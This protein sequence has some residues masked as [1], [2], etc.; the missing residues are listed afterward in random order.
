MSHGPLTFR[1]SGLGS[2]AATER[3]R[4]RDLILPWQALA[5]VQLVPDSPPPRLRV[6]EASC[7]RVY[8]PRN[9]TGS[10]RAGE[11]EGV[12]ERGEMRQKKGDKDDGQDGTSRDE[13]NPPR[14][15]TLPR[16]A[17]SPWEQT[18]RSPN[19]SVPFSQGAFE[20]V[21]PWQTSSFLNFVE[22]CGSQWAG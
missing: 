17:K 8:R 14:N 1:T 13:F 9:G 16:A 12:R 6:S 10:A 3:E 15:C 11:R 5:A 18:R 22:N 2:A 7:S 20:N 21:G 19:L 4:K